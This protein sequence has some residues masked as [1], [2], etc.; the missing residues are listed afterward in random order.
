MHE[1]KLAKMPVIIRVLKV[2]MS[3]YPKRS[4][5]DFL[6]QLKN[7]FNRFSVMSVRC[8]SNLITVSFQNYNPLLRLAFQLSLRGVY[9][10][11]WSNSAKFVYS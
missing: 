10:Q 7:I 4:C 5:L 11:V 9:C 8:L 2:Q 1:T 6:H 3:F